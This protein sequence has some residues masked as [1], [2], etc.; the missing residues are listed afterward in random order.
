MSG[1]KIAAIALLVLGTLALVYGGFSYTKSESEVDL[2]AISFEV[3]ER[4]HVKLPVWLGVGLI[5][6]GGGLL[7]GVGRKT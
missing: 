1:V 3:Q 6:V 2:G 7:V 5:V 4:E